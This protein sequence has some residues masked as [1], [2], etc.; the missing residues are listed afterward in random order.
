M[1]NE[2]AMFSLG[3]SLRILFTSALL[4][5]DLAD[6]VYIWEHFKESFC[7]DLMQQL[8]REN[9]IPLNLQEPHLDYGL[10]LIAHLLETQN[11]T[12]KDYGLPMYQHNWRQEEGNATP[13]AELLYDSDLSQKRSVEH[14]LN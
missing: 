11:K 5:G 3:K 6:P 14:L 4:T 7:D 8:T 12:L 13:R 2:A 1:F 10:F 9:V